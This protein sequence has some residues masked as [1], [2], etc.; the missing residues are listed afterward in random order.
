MC[1]DFYTAYLF[2]ITKKH[3]V[4]S[5]IYSYVSKL[6]R[7]GRRRVRKAK[8]L[9]PVAKYSRRSSPGALLV[10]I[11]LHMYAYGTT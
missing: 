10:V 8:N 11:Q 2:L 6:V 1:I 5:H 4:R 3:Y 9:V 7:Y